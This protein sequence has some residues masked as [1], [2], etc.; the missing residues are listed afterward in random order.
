[1]LAPEDRHVELVNER[2]VDG[3]PLE[4]ARLRFEV[5]EEGFWRIVV[6]GDEGAAGSGFHVF[7]F[8]KAIPAPFEGETG[9]PFAWLQ[10]GQPEQPE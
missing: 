7:G 2:K 6:Y 8:E 1:M 9:T 5:D 4:L 3:N 10:A